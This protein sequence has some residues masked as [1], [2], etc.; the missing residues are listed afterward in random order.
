MRKAARN[1][2]SSYSGAVEA[3]S[4]LAASRDCTSTSCY[5]INAAL[6]SEVPWLSSVTKPILAL[7]FRAFSLIC[8]FYAVDLP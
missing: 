8:V 7:A 3:A 2:L 4:A 1:K 5:L 6:P